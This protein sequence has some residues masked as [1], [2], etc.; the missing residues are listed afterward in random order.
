MANL[1]SG[2]ITTAVGESAGLVISA[3]VLVVV[4]LLAVAAAALA[5]MF[6]AAYLMAYALVVSFLAA[7]VVGAVRR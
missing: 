5:F 6:L 1:T 4:S 7:L 2:V 3:C